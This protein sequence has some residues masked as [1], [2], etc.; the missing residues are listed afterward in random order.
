M[1]QPPEAAPSQA[2]F[3]V[4]RPGPHYFFDGF[5]ASTHTSVK[6]NFKR[7]P[8]ITPYVAHFGPKMAFRVNL[9]R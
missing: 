5:Y 9:A 4:N 8:Q 1:R 2:V 6:S 3:R 7:Q